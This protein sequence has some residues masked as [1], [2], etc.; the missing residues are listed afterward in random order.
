MNF[1]YFFLVLALVSGLLCLIMPL[2][3]AIPMISLLVHILLM[4]VEMTRM[5]RDIIILSR[6][7]SGI[8]LLDNLKNNDRG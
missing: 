7:V 8:T 2:L 3:I 6:K 5:R 4:H 1:S